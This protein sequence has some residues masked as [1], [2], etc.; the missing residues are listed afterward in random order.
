MVPVMVPRSLTTI[1]IS[2]LLT[3]L[4]KKTVYNHNLRKCDTKVHKG[5]V[6]IEATR[7]MIANVPVHN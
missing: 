2:R 6:T 7:T 5:I 4:K 3:E 1:P